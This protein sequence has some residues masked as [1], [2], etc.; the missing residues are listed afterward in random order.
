MNRT[1]ITVTCVVTGQTDYLFA[2]TNQQATDYRENASRYL[3]MEALDKGWRW[4]SS[5]SVQEMTTF[6]SV[7]QFPDDTLMRELKY[8]KHPAN[9]TNF[10]M[11]DELGKVFFA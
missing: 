10:E 1:R 9:E 11:I 7:K 5:L 3:S 8:F 2:M 6:R 4:L